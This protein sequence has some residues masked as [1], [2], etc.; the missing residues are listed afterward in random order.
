MAL[1][2]SSA[3]ETNPMAGLAE[4]RSGKSLSAYVEIRITRDGSGSP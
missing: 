3:F 1:A 4:G 2:E